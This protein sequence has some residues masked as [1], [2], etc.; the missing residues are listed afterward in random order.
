MSGIKK[1]FALKIITYKGDITKRWFVAIKVADYN[2]GCWKWVKCYGDLNKIKDLTNRLAAIN[3]LAAQI[4]K[5]GNYTPTQG[6]RSIRT[7]AAIKEL[8]T[9]SLIHQLRERLTARL[10]RVRPSSVRKY[11]GILETLKNWLYAE[12]RPSI[13]PRQFTEGL[14]L[15]YLAS[16]TPASYNTHLMLLK[17]LFESLKA[18]KAIDTNPMAAIKSMRKKSLPSLYFQPAQIAILTNRIAANDPGLWLFIQFIYYCFIRPGELR[19]LKVSD[20]LLMEGKIIVPGH[21]SKNGK[22]QP[23]SIPNVLLLQLYDQGLQ[24]ANPDHYLF[25]KNPGNVPGPVPLGMNAMKT[26][27]REILKALNFNTRHKLY[28]WKHT[29][30]VQFVRAGGALKELQLQLRHHSLD[31][32]DQYLAGMGAMESKFIKEN[33]PVI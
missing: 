13:T 10:I 20:V 29:G 8:A 2:R 25:S 7:S 5:D 28:S 16:L 15:R 30:A 27:H 19:L 1:F 31:Q 4:K 23:V 26:R 21:I 14:A 9:T 17:S 3:K 11:S 22:E 33:F 18:I 6:A 32:V 24:F 12:G